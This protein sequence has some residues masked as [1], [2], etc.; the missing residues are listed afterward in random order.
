MY[1]YDWDADTGG[2]L[3]NSSPLS[4]SK[5]PRPVYYK[6]LDILGFDKYWNYEKDDSCPY[7]W[8]EANNYFYRGRHVAKTKGG[9]LYTPPELILLDDPEPEG[10]PLRF[11]DIQAMTE[12]NKAIIDKL[13]A[14]TIK[15]IYNTYVE[16]R[17]EVDIFHV[18]YSGGK[19]SEVTLDLVQ[20]AIPHTDFVVIFGDTGMEFPDTYLT[21]EK[22]KAYCEEQN[23][24]F[25]TAKS[26]QNVMDTWAK[27]GPPSKTIRWCCSV[28]KTSPQL[29]KLREITGKTN[30][31]ELSFVGVRSDESVR[32]SEYDYISFGTKHQG[33]Y[34]Y[35]P[36]LEW[37][38]AEVYPYI[39][40]NDLQL[41][42]A[43]KKGNS[44]AGCLVCPM[45]AD[46]SDYMRNA[47]YP[48]QVKAFMDMV[49]HTSVRSLSTAEDTL[50]Y[51]E[52]G[53]WKLRNN[54]RDIYTMP[55]KYTETQNSETITIKV[56]NPSTPWK[57]WIK[58]IGKL[59][60]TH[61]GYTI[62]NHGVII[63]FFIENHCDGYIVRVKRGKY[64]DEVKL[65]KLFKQVFRKAAYCIDCQECAANC[66]RGCIQMRDD[67]FD[68]SDQC[69]K[70]G[71]C[72]KIT[73]GCLLYHSLSLPKGTGKM[74]TTSLDYY[75]DH[76]PKMEWIKEFFNKENNFFESNSLG[77][78]MNN[79]FK[80][81]LK[82][83]EL[84][85]N[86]LLTE[87]AY[88]IKKIGLENPASWGLMLVN[89]AY[90]SE[91][92]W[93]IKN[94]KPYALYTKT[95]IMDMLI[96]SGAKERAS[97]S[98]SGAYRRI[99]ALPFGS[100]IGLGYVE[101][102]GKDYVYRRE[103][104]RNPDSKVILYSLYKFAEACGGYYQFTLTRLLNHDIES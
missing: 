86:N 58:T 17:D 35:N 70:C 14:D 65:L 84:T 103:S 34:S 59:N 69:V 4:F 87:F 6:E 41:N 62:E 93:Y 12:K 16:H 25:Y 29:L 72:H 36:I 26:S 23:I 55:V 89:L 37:N 79:M 48:E 3:L 92:Q 100:E 95:E 77:S 102:N 96:N 15:K 76:A 28:H 63:P 94:I 99:L 97:K 27:F 50:R 19:D 20:K 31:R 80:R 44:R 9:S 61:N 33:Q 64:A 51:I 85:E 8:A 104:W 7:M 54:G 43:Y 88:T 91:F 1:S 66:S 40:Q 18:S 71:N 101:K 75:A 67:F 74:D 83:A 42:D 82:D 46:K 47:C 10:V 73:D 21:V 53:G 68:I 52:L 32:R 56:F 90:T 2:I 78:V 5:E 24:A 60:Q 39:F 22:I 11:V 49:V 13:A 81:F 45:S 57:M 30:V 38:S 98:V